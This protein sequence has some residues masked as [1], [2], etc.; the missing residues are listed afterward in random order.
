MYISI[1]IPV[2]NEADVLAGNLQKLQSVREQGHEIVMV[3]GGSTDESK[4]LAEPYVDHL[5]TS[6]NGRARQMNTGAEV[7]NAEVL[8][9]LHVDTVL[10]ED[11]ID[12]IINAIKPGEESWGRFDVRLSGNKRFFRL[13]E[14]MMNWRSRVSGIATGDQGIFISRSLFERSHGFSDIPLM[15][16]VELCRRLKKIKAPICL[17]QQVITSSRR[18]ELGGVC[19]TIF[20]M[21]RLR[22]AYWLGADPTVLARQYR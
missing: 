14:T 3:D 18:W 7:A 17:S 21:W 15:E 11:G 20:L 22:L 16:D 19:R 9:F 1:I 13:I 8:L 2:L 6:R 10:P 12:A 4:T 5:M